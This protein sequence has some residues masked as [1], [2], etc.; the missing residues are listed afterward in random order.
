M[1][2]QLRYG[3]SLVDMGCRPKDQTTQADGSFAGVASRLDRIEA[4]LLDRSTSRASATSASASPS[5]AAA[6]SL[7][8]ISGHVQ[9]DRASLRRNVSFAR[10]DC[11][12][13]AR[14]EGHDCPPCLRPL[15]TL[16]GETYLQHEM[17]QGFR[18]YQTLDTEAG[19]Q[20]SKKEL[21]L[22]PRTCWRLQ[23]SFIAHLLPWFPLFSQQT[24]AD[25]VS[26]ASESNFADLGLTLDTRGAGRPLNGNGSD[27]ASSRS[28]PLP[29]W[30]S[31]L[32]AALALF[33]LALGAIS[34]Q[35]QYFGDDPEN[36]HGR[37][38][39]LSACDIEERQSRA[40]PHDIVA[41]QC[42]LLKW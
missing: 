10:L 19:S 12:G 38:Y 41:I 35:D 37:A 1:V 36:L 40:R 25:I 17:E 20:T 18:L 11:T 23:Q 32:D 4:L 28:R 33:I 14:L 27:A 6:S 31:K 39:F 15:E 13:V 30:R 2:P 8:E 7:L 34:R 21:D 16:D 3:K 22:S 42:K 24:C 29:T 26:H 5:Y 9:V